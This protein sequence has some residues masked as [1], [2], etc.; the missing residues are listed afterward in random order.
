MLE[1]DRAYILVALLLALAGMLLGLY[2]GIASDNKL[3]PVHVALMLTGFVT[4][5][6]YGCI[7][8]LWPTMKK[9][10]LAPAQFWGA[11]VGE[12]AIVVG[13]YFFVVNGSVPIVATGSVLAIIAAAL[14]IW[15]F[16]NESAR[17]S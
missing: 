14:L 13:A 5:A 12:L 10:P 16:W 3:L 11:T 8:R 17:S 2:M 1:I 6:I 15:L 4:L 9:A 7:F